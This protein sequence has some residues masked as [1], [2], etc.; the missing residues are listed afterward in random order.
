MS[1]FLFIFFLFSRVTV[2]LFVDVIA[3]LLTVV[4]RYESII[5][6]MIMMSMQRCSILML[7]KLNKLNYELHFCYAIMS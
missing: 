2:S 3:V 5:R 7:N 1:Y 4:M 6:N